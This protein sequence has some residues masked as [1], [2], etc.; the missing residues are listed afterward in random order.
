MAE[1]ECDLLLFVA[2]KTELEQLRAAA[3][4]RHLTFESVDVIGDQSRQSYWLGEVGTFRTIAV[5][6]RMGA[7][8]YGG[9]AAT[10]FHFMSKTRATQVVCVGMAFGVNRGLQRFG[11]VLV[12]DAVFPY[13]QRDVVVANGRWA[14][15][16]GDSATTYRASRE[17][18]AVL[19]Q[20][21]RR[22]DADAAGFRVMPGCLLTGNA[23]IRA[24]GYRDD[25]IRWSSHV[26]SVVV[27]G[28][29]EGVGLLS[30]SPKGK[31]NWMIVKGVCDF[32]DE[33]QEDEVARNRERACRNAANFV[34][35]ALSAWKPGAT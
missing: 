7:L 2:T 15:S 25:V 22:H 24:A 19:E 21:R 28:E 23:R 17:V 10:G 14:Y 1:T 31:P 27:G 32:A 30:L 6:T 12:S 13:E 29:M 16:Y 8:S 20:Q 33:Q 5:K 11:D 18:F 35:D 34:L 4:D 26:A 9:S 3:D